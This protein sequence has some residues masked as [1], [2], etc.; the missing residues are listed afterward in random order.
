[1]TSV[2]SSEKSLFL[3]F[4]LPQYKFLYCVFRHFY[5]HKEGFVLFGISAVDPGKCLCVAPPLVSDS[6]TLVCTDLLTVKNEFWKFFCKITVF[7]KLNSKKMVTV[8]PV[9]DWWPV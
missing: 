2:W 3:V 7:L 9:M 5:N 6:F 8:W 1:M 4:F